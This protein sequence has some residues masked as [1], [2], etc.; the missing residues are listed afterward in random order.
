MIIDRKVI[1]DIEFSDT[2]ICEDYFFKC[3]LLKRVG[4]AYSFDKILTKYR[5]R[6]DSLQSNK[7]RNLYWIWKINKNNNKLNFF[8]N[9]LS[10]IMISINSLKK[11]GFK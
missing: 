9:V 2:K 4:L 3:L 7:I 1:K 6:K 11:Y 5:V 8:E 10:L